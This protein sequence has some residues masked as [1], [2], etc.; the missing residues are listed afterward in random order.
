M[1]KGSWITSDWS[2]M[3]CVDCGVNCD[4]FRDSSQRVVCV[5]C[6]NKREFD[7]LNLELSE[8]EAA[9]S[10]MQADETVVIHFKPCAL[11]NCDHCREERG[12]EVNRKIHEGEIK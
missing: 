1:Y 4:L 8:H 10:E 2:P 9:E 3:V 5:D 6:L 12:H 11:K 7:E